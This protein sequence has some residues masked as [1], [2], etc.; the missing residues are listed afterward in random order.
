M[1]SQLSRI[2]VQN[3]IQKRSGTYVIPA[4]QASEG[5]A[6]PLLSSYTN[7]GKPHIRNGALTITA[8]NDESYDSILNDVMSFYFEDKENYICAA[9][10]LD[11]LKTSPEYLAFEE[12]LKPS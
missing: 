6:A 9:K 4:C 12:E 10:L 7:R 5:Q 1:H 8:Y 11:E 2:S 3:Q